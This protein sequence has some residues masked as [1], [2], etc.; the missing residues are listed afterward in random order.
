LSN[1]DLIFLGF[2][3]T[4]FVALARHRL[5]ISRRRQDGID[6]RRRRFV[7]FI[8]QFKAE[9]IA[10]RLPDVWVPYFIQTVPELK[11][12][13]DHIARDLNDSARVKLNEQVDTVLSF[14]GM[15]PADIYARQDELI[16]AIESIRTFCDT[17]GKENHE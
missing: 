5:A 4:L 3:V 10:P 12:R 11:A 6:S 13:F 15:N 16:A 2:A 1:R 17:A 14:A 8:V 9:I 7:D